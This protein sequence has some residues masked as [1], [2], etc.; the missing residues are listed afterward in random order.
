MEWLFL[1]C[2][3]HWIVLRLVKGGSK[4][5]FLAFSPL[6]TMEDS[7]V[8]FR[9]FLGAILS[10]VKGVVVGASASDDSQIFDTIDKE[11]EGSSSISDADGGSGEYKVRSGQ[12]PVGPRAITHKHAQV[13]SK[14]A[15][16]M[17]RPSCHPFISTGDL[18]LISIDFVIFPTVA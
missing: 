8:P 2:H 1:T 11:E 10:V 14:K 5:P 4:P 6:I 7:S 18:K 3:N 16:L 13:T 12:G 17:V 15:P 9:A